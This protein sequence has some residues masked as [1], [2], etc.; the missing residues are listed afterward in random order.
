LLRRAAERGRCFILP[1]KPVAITVIRISSVIV[2]STTVP[3]M[4]FASSWASAWISEEASWI[5]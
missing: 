1:A 2:S 4:M 5:S 3:K